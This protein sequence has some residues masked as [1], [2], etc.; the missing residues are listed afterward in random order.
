MGW[1]R[2]S[3]DPDQQLIRE[4]NEVLVKESQTERRERY[5]REH[6]YRPEAAPL[7]AL[8]RAERDAARDAYQI[9]QAVN[10]TEYEKRTGKEASWG[11][12]S[13]QVVDELIHA[14]NVSRVRQAEER[15]WP[16]G[17]KSIIKANRIGE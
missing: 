11:M 5:R 1:F 6:F 12:N 4:Q 3:L 13:S 7:L 15:M 10:D 2:R 9:L 8:N 17:S 14:I 16:L